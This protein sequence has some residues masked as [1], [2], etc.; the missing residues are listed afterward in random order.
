[1]DIPLLAR[2]V[3]RDQGLG[4]SGWRK[5]GWQTRI[6]I[7]GKAVSNSAKMKHLSAFPTD[8]PISCA[9]AQLLRH[10]GI[11][12]EPI[13]HLQGGSIVIQFPGDRLSWIIRIMEKE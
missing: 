5:R 13:S 12:V 7:R 6:F 3:M 11:P 9:D 2:L 4:G 8:G 10:V 1:M